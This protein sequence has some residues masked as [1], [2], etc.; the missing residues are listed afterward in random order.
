MFGWM[1]LLSSC[2]SQVSRSASFGNKDVGRVGYLWSLLL[3]QMGHFD[4]GSDGE[5]ALR[6]LKKVAELIDKLKRKS[7][8]NIETRSCSSWEVFEG[9]DTAGASIKCRTNPF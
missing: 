1:I 3:S 2:P 4:L 5:L 6:L 9:E 7:L 8:L